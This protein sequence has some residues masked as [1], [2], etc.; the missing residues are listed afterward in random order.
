MTI[1]YDLNSSIVNFLDQ[2]QIRVMPLRF[3]MHTCGTVTSHSGPKGKKAELDLKTVP[4]TLPLG[5]QL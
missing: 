1:K 4:R 5:K 3:C 2:V